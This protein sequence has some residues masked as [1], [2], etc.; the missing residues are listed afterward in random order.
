M[1]RQL[2]AAAFVMAATLF[3]GCAGAVVVRYGPPPP[4]RY[5]VVG[6]APGPGFVWT[7]GFYDWRGGA[8]MW[9]PGRWMR[10]PRPRAVWVPGA[11]MQGR[12]GYAF[13]RGYWR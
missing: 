11:W 3:T 7:E 4:P 12:H 6:V 13:H 8:Y 10:P 1:K 5:G 9:V 2:L